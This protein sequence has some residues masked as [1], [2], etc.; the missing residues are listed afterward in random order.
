MQ[1]NQKNLTFNASYFFVLTFMLCTFSYQEIIKNVIRFDIKI[2]LIK[3]C[4]TLIII[5]LSNDA[6]YDFKAKMLSAKGPNEFHIY[7]QKY[8]KEASVALSSNL[9]KMTH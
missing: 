6:C 1:G 2:I 7:V 8:S 3:F 9:Q 5:K 4:A